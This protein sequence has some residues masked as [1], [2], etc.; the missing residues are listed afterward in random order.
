M[1]ARC[2]NTAM[3]A[4]QNEEA[5]F[6]AQNLINWPLYP[7]LSPDAM[8]DPKTLLNAPLTALH[9]ARTKKYAL[10]LVATVLAIGVLGFFV[11]PPLAKWIL[12]GQLGEALHRPVSVERIRINPYTLTVQVDGLAVQEK[13]GGETV[14]GFDHLYANLATASLLRGGPVFS[15]IRLDGPKFRIVRLADNRYN[16]SD[17]IDQWMAKPA[18]DAPNPVFSLNNIQISKGLLE[19]DDRPLGVKHRVDAINLGLPFVSSMAYATDIF[20]EPAFSARINGA[21]LLLKGRSKPFADS[22]ESE[23]VLELDHLQLAQYLGYIPFHLPIKVAAGALDSDLKL[24]FR[25]EKDQ[26]ATLS[27]SGTLAVKGLALN[28]STG[29]PLLALK[30]LDLSVGSAELL[31]RKFVIDR[32]SV[33]SPEIYARV[34]QQGDINWLGLLP[35]PTASAES[36]PKAT[37][38]PT[39]KTSA[40]SPPRWSLA[41]IKVSGGAFRWLDESHG[42]PFRAS[43]DAFNFDL[44]KLD[45]QGTTPAEFDISWRVAADEWLKVEAFSA[46]GGRLDWAK[47]ELSLDEVLAKGVRIMMRRAADG[48]LDW[49]KP[50]SLRAAQAAQQEPER[51]AAWKLN[52]ARYVGEDVG[53]RFE[54]AAVSPASTQTIEGLGFELE[55][56]STELGQA[57]KLATRFKLNRKGQVEVGGTVKL[58]P[59]D[60]DLTLNLKAV[61]LLPLQ[62][63]FGEK[64][65]IALKRGQL[66]LDG[67]LKLR[68]EDLLA[69]SAGRKGWVGGFSGRTTI[70]D[71]LSVDKASSE[72]FLKWKS[73]YF[74]HIDVHHSPDS[75]SVG[76]VALTD[77][78]ARVMV[79]PQ[80]QLNLLQIV[81]QDEPPAAPPGAKISE[82]DTTASADGKAI[83]PVKTVAEAVEAAQPV[84]PVKIGKVTLQGGSVR[85]TDNFV[86][87][88]YSANL[89]Q[90]GG[91][92]SGLSSDAESTAEVDL[93]GSYDNV[94]PLSI[95]GRINPLAAKPLLDLQAEIKSVE[96]TSLSPYSGKYAGYAI[97]KGKLSLFVNY[98]IENNKLEAENRVFIDQ[99]TFGEPVDSPDATKLPVT[100][101]VSLLKNRNGEI[102]INLPI[103]GSLDDP[104]FSVGELIVQVI[105][106]LLGKAITSPFALLGLASGGGGELSSLDFDDGR[107]SIAP[108]AQQRLEK[109]A[110][111]LL[112]R[113]ALKLEIEGRADR[114]RD[115]EGLKRVRI[116]RKV[117]ALKLEDAANGAADSAPDSGPAASEQEYPALLERAYRAEKFPKPRNLVGMVKTL[118]VAETEKLMLTNSAV[119]DDDLRALGERRAK[120]VRDWLIGHEVPAERIFLLP[121]KLEEA[122]AS[123]A[124]SE[125]TRVS[126][127]NFSLK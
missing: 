82:A 71:F 89:K 74:G 113:P 13:G 80:G 120:A 55:N 46:K 78:F 95:T 21:E 87:P 42:K 81:R 115:R 16:F 22:L 19:F 76:E 73:L 93:R 109:L 62:P 51:S 77:F 1:P 65:N 4:A 103:S 49:V 37:A 20:V 11:L 18:P 107:S 14:A 32:L 64:L 35:K 91:R 66:A 39:P 88:N 119:D 114:E 96:M 122:D 125:K 90:L 79:S 110:T 68:Q 34:D 102:D 67:H 10:R 61:E 52:V 97:D 9:S 72:D 92:I 26:P 105:I 101:A 70:G 111:A 54:D 116:E 58:F 12:V 126:R 112:D 108:P 63:Y 121:V 44:K 117:R 100:L 69:S 84:L 28:E 25:H 53:L 23:L 33:D 29:A 47:H 38:P 118:P 36:D 30:R 94:A 127:A 6:S 41:E 43:V 15:E 86:Q 98:K 123:S 99:L 104:Q 75:L 124:A 83:A 57:I 24:V 5:R 50:P 8:I 60:A 7:R 31:S 3:A 27:L 85:F 59:L 45:G 17:L 106:N 48:S 56:L 2:L 40:P